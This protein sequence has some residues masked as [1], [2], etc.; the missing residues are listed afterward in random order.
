MQ[1]S[2]DHIQGCIRNLLIDQGPLFREHRET[3]YLGNSMM[4]DLFFYW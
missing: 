4:T 2:S 3:T 1:Q